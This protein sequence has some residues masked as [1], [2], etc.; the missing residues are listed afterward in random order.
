MI[1]VVHLITGL[2]LG[3]AERQ[4]IRLVNHSNV[5]KFSHIVVSMQDEGFLK[6]ELDQKRIKLY[7]LNMRKSNI[8]L[9]AL[10]RLIKILKNE[11]PFLLQTWLYHADFLG[12][13]AAKLAKVPNI[14]WNIRCSN[15]EMK[16]YAFL[17]RVIMKICS[18]L[19]CFTDGIIVN[20]HIGLRLHQKYGYNPK[21]W[22][23]IPNGFEVN[24][25]KPNMEFRSAIRQ[26]LLL[27]D[28]DF[29]VG[30]IA[31]FDPMKDHVTFLKAASALAKTVPNIKFLLVGKNIDD[32]N[33]VLI[34]TIEAQNLKGKILLLGVHQKIN[35]LLCAL[36]LLVSSSSFGEGFPNV[37]GEAMASGVPCIATDVGD[38]R[39]ILENA[40][41]IVP[42]ND[43]SAL[44]NAIEW[45]LN[46]SS[47]ERALLGQLGR[48]RI[49]KNYA[50]SNMLE[51]YQQFYELLC[52]M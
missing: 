19:S 29:V 11:K 49:V 5:E 16:H 31:R 18:Y 13:I 4:L 1:K 39:I 36:D 3:G 43:V 8:N 52:K 51:N 50:L 34:K 7:T 25:F 27:S 35:E 33:S 23:W 44:V 41:K 37:L 22:K 32:S 14:V 28:M 46:M 26:K 24:K 30:M 15:M 17:T 48:E 40:G 45:I 38:S 9:G 10:F 42:P 21:L 20:S 47:N 2:G 12:F 6:N